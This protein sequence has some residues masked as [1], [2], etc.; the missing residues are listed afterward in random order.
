[1][2]SG[3]HFLWKW[4]YYTENIPLIIQELGHDN[5]ILNKIFLWKMGLGFDII[6]FDVRLDNQPRNRV[7]ESRMLSSWLNDILRICT[8]LQ[9]LAE[10]SSSTPARINRALSSHIILNVKIT[11][12]KVPRCSAVSTCQEREQ[13]INNLSHELVFELKLVH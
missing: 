5:I 7:N 4:C 10:V 13:W 6:S 11:F 2:F 12:P 9:T 8:T 3:T 1:M